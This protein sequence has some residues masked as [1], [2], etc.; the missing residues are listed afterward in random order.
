V[1]RRPSS[2][3]RRFLSPLLVLLS[4]SATLPAGAAGYYAGTQGARAAGRAGAFTA[5]ADD[6]TAVIY[7]PAGL[8][9]ID[10]NLVQLS[11]RF[12]YSTMEFTR[13]PTLDWTSEEDGVAPLHRF[14]KV[15][16]QQPLQLLNPLLGAASKLGLRDW[17]FAVVAFSPAGASHLAFPLDGGQRYLMVER[18][19]IIL[20]YSATAAYEYQGRFGIG[21]SLQW[22]AVPRLRYSLVIDANPFPKQSNPIAASL[23]MH[24]TTTG[25][26]PFT[27]NAVLG[28]WY[29]PVPSLELG[30]SGQ[31]IPS[32]IETKSKLTI[33][34][35]RP[36]VAGNVVL[37]RDGEPVDDVR[38]RLPLPVTARAGVRYRQLDGARERFDVELDVAYESWSRVK[39]FSLDSN[40]IQA[41]FQGG[42][43]DVGVIDIEKQWRDT[44]SVSLGGDYALVPD[45]FT[46]R[47]GVFYDSAVA[48]PAYAS[49]DFVSGQQLGGTLGASVRLSKLELALA[50][51]YRVQPSFRVSEKDARGYQEVPGSRCQAPFT[52]PDN[53]DPHYLG[54]PAPAV[55]AGKYAARSHAASV[56]AL[57]RF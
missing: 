47:A 49:V 6:L 40:G 55:N 20:N 4:T 21:A 13:A 11:N 25:S 18:E 38:V 50:Y 26:D 53:C 42:T 5:K 10:E 30:I 2:H 9:H 17:T 33:D 45:F 39:R 14:D 27:L 37:R 51:E 41:S 54:Q 23:D 56:D 12:S 46:L 48:K 32:Q 57:Y 44:V 29:R 34:P 24:A 36:E 15:H 3:L 1:R 7:N 22:I 28:A 16:N 52:D 19:A 43:L 35:V 8:A 31:V